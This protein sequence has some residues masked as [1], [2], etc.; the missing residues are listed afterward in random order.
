MFGR[1]RRDEIP[2]ERVQPLKP[3]LKAR[4]P[5]TVNNVLT[6]LSMLLKKAGAWGAIER[7]PFVIRL[8][9]IPSP[10]ALITRSNW[11]LPFAYGA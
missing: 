1:R 4:S 6:T 10:S 11:K 5:K 9:P 8:L 7:L 3:T 2:T